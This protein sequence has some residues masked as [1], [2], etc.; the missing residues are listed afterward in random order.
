MLEFHF[1]P[2]PYFTNSVSK[3]SVQYLLLL[4]FFDTRNITF[5]LKTFILSLGK[6]LGFVVK[7]FHT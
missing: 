4:E 5:S 2:N 7:V 3:T 1:S 6:C